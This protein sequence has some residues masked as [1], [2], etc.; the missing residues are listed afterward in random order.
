M[1]MVICSPFNGVKLS[2]CGYG[3]G[4]VSSLTILPKTTVDTLP[5]YG[6]FV[7]LNIYVQLTFIFPSLSFCVFSPFTIL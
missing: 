7:G 3:G 6:L 5:L 4:M 1:H 2:I